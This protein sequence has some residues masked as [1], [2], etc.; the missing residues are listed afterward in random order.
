MT[1]LR[2]RTTVTVSDDHQPSQLPA[3]DVTTL[4]CDDIDYHNHSA[5]NED[6]SDTNQTFV[7]DKNDRVTTECQCSSKRM[8]HPTKRDD[9]SPDH[10]TATQKQMTTKLQSS[11][12]T[13]NIYNY[14]EIASLDREF[15]LKVCEEMNLHHFNSAELFSIPKS[16][17]SLQIKHSIYKQTNIHVNVCISQTVGDGNCLFRALSLAITQNEDN[18][19]VIRSYVVNHM[20][21][22]EIT[23]DMANLFASRNNQQQSFEEHLEE[24]QRPGTW[25]TEQEI[26]SAAHLFNCSIL[27]FS[28]YNSTGQVCIQHFPPHF[29]S[30]PS[31]ANS[32]H[33]KSLYLI[34]TGNHYEPATVFYNLYRVSQHHLVDVEP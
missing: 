17:I 5:E 16:P 27:C 2:A 20:L 18:H 8:K 11:P 33:H 12:S 26:V 34:N 4:H 24:M 13:I 3:S 25:G 32:C 1:E 7:N 15:Q 10:S 29:V 6:T 22:P 14:C 31:C 19:D 30:N 21:H 9:I 23:E 28:Q